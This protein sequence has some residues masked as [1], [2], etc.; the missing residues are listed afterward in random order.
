MKDQ[1]ET[2]EEVLCEVEMGNLPGKELRTV[3][4]KMIKRL[5]RIM[6]YRARS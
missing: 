5:G 4:I 3:I 2:T 6:M 1:D